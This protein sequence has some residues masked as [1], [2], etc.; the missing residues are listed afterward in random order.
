MGSLSIVAECVAVGAITAVALTLKR[1][2][3][4]IDTSISETALAGFVIGVVVHLLFELSGAN[5]WYC[6]HGTACQK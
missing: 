3:K 2:I 1:Y 4:P 6:V 5:V